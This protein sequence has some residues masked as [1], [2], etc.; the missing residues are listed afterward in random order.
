M[1]LL[2]EL[3]NYPVFGVRE[4]SNICGADKN[5]AKLVLYRLKKTGAIFPLERDKYTVHTD[6]LVVASRLVWPSYISSWGAIRHYNLTEQL[7]NYIEVV[8]T[9]PRKSKEKI[10]TFMNA[11]IEFIKIKREYFF[12]YK[13][14]RYGENDIFIAD[15]EKALA[16][17]LYLGQMS[18]ETVIETIREHKEEID[19]DLLKKYLKRMKM[20]NVL[21]RLKEVSLDDKQKRT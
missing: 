13:K 21:N 19:V 2:K 5:Y 7:P 14:I 9:R 11:N 8:T 1:I 6:P 10:I 4:I 18:F 17:A 12:G 3:Q 20:A 15:K 16:D